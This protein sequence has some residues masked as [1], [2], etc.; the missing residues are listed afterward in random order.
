[1]LCYLTV[2]MSV[3]SLSCLV[4]LSKVP[5]L[6]C[7][8]QAFRCNKLHLFCRRP[9]MITSSL[10]S[11][12]LWIK[13][14]HNQHFNS[15]VIVTRVIVVAGEIYSHNIDLNWFDPGWFQG[16][17]VFQRGAPPGQSGWL[18]KIRYHPPAVAQA[19]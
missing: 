1:M 8:M 2:G 7:L 17:Y 12:T 3:V 14:T 15:R 19:H 10:I 16:F 9:T 13:A 11:E 18:H 5:H 4:R 6:F